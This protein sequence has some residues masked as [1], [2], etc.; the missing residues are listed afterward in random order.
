[1]EV[2]SSPVGVYGDSSRVGNPLHYTQAR[3]HSRCPKNFHKWI[4]GKELGNVNARL[5]LHTDGRWRRKE[6]KKEGRKKGERR[7]R[8]GEGRSL[9]VNP[10][11]PKGSV[12]AGCSLTCSLIPGTCLHRVLGACEGD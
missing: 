2:P 6:G 5:L 3:D 10:R 1:M 12:G 9:Y 11:F 4:R 7:E 8:G